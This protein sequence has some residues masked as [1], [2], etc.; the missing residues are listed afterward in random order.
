MGRPTGFPALRAFAL[1]ALLS[2]PSCL[3]DGSHNASASQP[4]VVS[5]IGVAV[6]TPALSD[7]GTP[8]P[9]VQHL[10]IA[11]GNSSN[12]RVYGW[13]AN[14]GQLWRWGDELLIGFVDE[15]YLWKGYWQ[16][17]KDTTVMAKS[18][19]AR[20]TDGGMTWAVEH[21]P[22]FGYQDS[23]V[24]PGIQDS[25]ALSQ[26]I[27][28]THP[29]FC[30]SFDMMEHTPYEG[31][32]Q[33]FH[34][35]YDRGHTWS[36]K[37]RLPS[38]P[39]YT[40][41]FPRTDIIVDGPNAA[42]V[43]VTGELNDSGGFVT[44][45]VSVLRTTDGGRNWTT[46]GQVG[47]FKRGYWAGM[48]SSVR[49]SSTELVSLI[50]VHRALV[51]GAPA[52]VVQASEL[53]YSADN[54]ATWSHRSTPLIHQRYHS[55]SG[56]ILLKLPD[57][58]LFCSLGNRRS[59]G[60][61]FS[62]YQRSAIQGRLSADGGLT[63][64]PL[65]TLRGDAGSW[66]IGYCRGTVL[67]DG[68]V[69]VAYYWC[70][71]ITDTGNFNGEEDNH[72]GFR[73]IDATLVDPSALASS[74]GD[75]PAYAEC[76]AALVDSGTA[77]WSIDRAGLRSAGQI[78]KLCQ[79]NCKDG[80]TSVSLRYASPNP[81]KRVEIRADGTGG[82]LLGTFVTSNTGGWTSFTEQSLP[83]STLSGIHT[84]L[85]VSK[86]ADAM[87]LTTIRFSGGTPL[88]TREFP[89]VADATAKQATPDQNSPGINIRASDRVAY[90]RFS[91]QGLSAAPVASVALR[92]TESPEGSAGNTT[93]EVRRVTGAWDEATLT[94][95]TRPAAALTGWGAFL[96]G[97]LTESQVI[98]IPL[99]PAM[100]TGDGTYDVELH[101]LGGS[102]DSEFV[103]REL[104]AGTATLVVTQ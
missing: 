66:D 2:S 68:R 65:Y 89:C 98:L 29:D 81:G 23:S 96:T 25:S 11:Q 24:P 90:L 101:P 83:L 75:R 104:G 6:P 9:G 86:D 3:G 47:E 48:S 17:T 56:A 79:M 63:W 26:P 32:D 44:G 55:T 82:P 53:W 31:K 88:Q 77:N 57:G 35:S 74:G 42:T 7:Q 87:D 99:D 94:W 70:D 8:V 18:A 49:L 85:L 51:S 41:L 19:L 93:F 103:R 38:N 34:F 45:N 80:L 43:F 102:I 36:G 69:M 15:H 50:R 22:T 62:A 72:R 52:K 92:L 58:K 13:P 60:Q 67:A 76:E 64:G 73:S 33:Y 4:G 27:N 16:H 61:L 39:Q 78:L 84:L 20:S 54:G 97:T 46:I 91:V 95:N 5:G 71:R 10:R 12:Q 40:S 1:A 28:F 37:Y 100:I 21:P 14:V 59:Y 30:L